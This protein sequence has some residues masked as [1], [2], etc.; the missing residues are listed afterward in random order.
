MSKI[1]FIG[2]IT[3]LVVILAIVAAYC[4]NE[5][6]IDDS[7]YQILSVSSE[8]PVKLSAIIKDVETGSYYEG[9]DNETLAW[10]KSLGEKSVFSGN[11]TF[12][13][14]SSADARNL[15]SEYVTD[16]FIT[17]QMKCIVLENRS[18]GDVEYPKD[19]ILVKNVEYLGEN[20]TYFDV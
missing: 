9:Y 20:I 8:G 6:S 18:L 7:D 5:S 11:G 2:I 16:A 14:M 17:Q 19:V 3:I 12:V 10:M 13:V 1:T 4:L 15:H